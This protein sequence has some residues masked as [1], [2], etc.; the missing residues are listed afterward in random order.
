MPVA[1]G[2]GPEAVGAPPL[3]ALQ[4]EREIARGLKAI[5]G[6]L[7][8]AMPHDRLER[9]R[10]GG[11]VASEIQRF[12]A[13]DRRHR[14]GRRLAVK[15]ALCR[16]PSRTARSRSKKCRTVDRPAGR[17]PARATCSRPCRGPCRD[18]SGAG[19]SR[20]LLA[21]TLEPTARARPKSRIFT[22]P[23]AQTKTFS[24]F[25]SRCAMPL[26]VRGRQAVARSGRRSR[27]PCAGGNGAPAQALPQRLADEQLQH[28][29]RHAVLHAE[30]VDRE[31]VRMR[32]RRDGPRFALEPRARLRDRWPGAAAGP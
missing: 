27:S 30:V 28:G 6:P 9:R 15:G 11:R 10:D 24:G 20:Q 25:R 1:A 21:Q 4:D 26:L 23:S 12:L 32:Q 18:R 13:E 29:V 8:E 16:S 3:C 2:C 14:L 5:L 17:A 22:R 19:R 31:D 7:L